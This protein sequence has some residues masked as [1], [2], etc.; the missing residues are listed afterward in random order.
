LLLAIALTTIVAPATRAQERV[1]L[2][3]ELPVEALHC[4][5]QGSLA[6]GIDARVREEGLSAGAVV[7]V[8]GERVRPEVWRLHI[9]IA[10]EGESIG[11]RELVVEETECET[12]V[13][14]I[15]LVVVL[16]LRGS[17][18]PEPVVEGAGT[19]LPADAEGDPPVGAFDRPDRVDTSRVEEP[20]ARAHRD[21]RATALQLRA[22]GGV[23][24]GSD[25]PVAAVA[26]FGV[27]LG[28]APSLSIG[29]LALGRFPSSVDI[30]GG[31]LVLTFVG[32]RIYGC[33]TL[34]DAPRFEI[35]PCLAVTAGVLRSAA[36]D[37]DAWNGTSADLL[38][39]AGPGIRFRVDVTSSIFVQAE[40]LAEVPLLRPALVVLRDPDRSQA[41]VYRSPILTVTP[42][43]GLGVELH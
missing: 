15:A 6:D 42:T 21:R 29:A 4:L 38:S 37:F 40:L 2:R 9:A 35:G 7:E 10:V 34:L 33:V 31:E 3:L 14:A 32:G 8:T 18:E 1:N 26:A 5:H 22:D 43:F 16:A 28:L 11:E 23:S 30:A 12:A 27:E 41:G 20:P 19:P 39:S 25:E 36:R 17:R 24:F 13:D